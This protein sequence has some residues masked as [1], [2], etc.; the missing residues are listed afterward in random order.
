MQITIEAHYNILFP[1]SLPW[2]KY[3]RLVNLYRGNVRRSRH[4]GY[5]YE[6]CSCLLLEHA[7]NVNESINQQNIYTSIT[8][9]ILGF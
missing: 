8:N 9:L 2:K 6:Q 7:G 5:F 4:N 1:C 3:F